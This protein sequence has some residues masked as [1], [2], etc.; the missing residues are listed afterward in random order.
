MIVSNE[1]DSPKPPPDGAKNP[2]RKKIRCTNVSHKAHISKFDIENTQ[3][4]Q[5][6]MQSSTPELKFAML[7]PS[8]LTHCTSVA[9]LWQHLNNQK[10]TKTIENSCIRSR[11]ILSEIRNSNRFGVDDDLKIILKNNKD[12]IKVINHRASS[13][14][15]SDDA[16]NA[17]TTNNKNKKRMNILLLWNSVRADCV[18]CV[19]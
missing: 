12:R 13:R 19:C 5:N 1:L 3:M 2:I 10:K 18:L 14:L 15:H 9:Q 7:A 8:N 6:W 4:F 16:L 17:H 11:Q